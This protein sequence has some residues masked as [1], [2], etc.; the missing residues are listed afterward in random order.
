MNQAST[1]PRQ[2]FDFTLCKEEL[3]GYVLQLE[4]CVWLWVGRGSLNSLHLSIFPRSTPV[5][6]SPESE[7]TDGRIALRVGKLFPDK[8]VFFSTDL[9]SDNPE[10]WNELYNTLLTSFK[11]M[12]SSRALPL[13]TISKVC[14]RTLASKP[15]KSREDIIREKTPKGKLDVRDFM[16]KNKD[17]PAKSKE[18]KV[19]VD[20]Y[21]LKH[22]E[23]VNQKTGEVDGPAGPEPTRFGDWER[24]GRV[25][26]F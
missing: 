16:E 3:H 9:I 14:S 2:D 18:V 12:L 15:G 7:T 21:L 6:H 26:D 23:G 10:Y 11:E 13:Q 17:K 25:S 5:L 8:Q 20:P 22:P 24:K 19:Y 1:S 4:G